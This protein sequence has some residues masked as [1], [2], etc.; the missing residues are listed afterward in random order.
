METKVSPLDPDETA[1]PEIFV[2]EMLRVIG[3]FGM[4]TRVTIES[5]DWR[6]LALLQRQA[7]EVPTVYLTA[8]QDWMDNV[9]R[10]SARSPWTSPHHVSACGGSIP[11]M[12]AAA[13]GAV[14]SPYFEEVSE[15]TIDEAHALG[16]GVVVWTV[17]DEHDMRRMIAL[18]VD[19]IMSD[20]PD[21]LV[22]LVRS[23]GRS[24]AV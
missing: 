4:G 17:N 6:T 19:G 9:C 12:I 24:A 22:R 16:L 20:Y 3:E 2:E 7:P 15:V 8:E 18:G 1:S 5:F 23:E 13:G 10:R 21:A 14:W 11:R